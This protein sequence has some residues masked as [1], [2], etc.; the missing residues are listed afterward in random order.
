M[1]DS[2]VRVSYVLVSER[3]RL[4]VLPSL[5]LIRYCFEHVV[6]IHVG[7][8][9]CLLVSQGKENIDFSSYN[10]RDSIHTACTKEVYTFMY[11]R[12]F[13]ELKEISEAFFGIYSCRRDR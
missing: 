1:H 2:V 12:Q 8:L 13:Q 5:R 11:T 10:F 9:L 7:G 3:E 6:D 4:L